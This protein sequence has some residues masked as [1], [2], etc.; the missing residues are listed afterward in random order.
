MPTNNAVTN[1]DIESNQAMSTKAPNSKHGMPIVG[2]HTDIESKQFMSPKVRHTKGEL[3]L[4]QLQVDV[5]GTI[6]VMIGRMWDISAVTNRYLSTD[7]VVSDAKSNM[8]HCTPRANVAHNFL[9]LKERAIYSIK[10][11]VVKPN[12]EEYHILKN[13]TFMLEFDG[14]TT[15]IKAFVKAEVFVRYPFQLADFD[16]IEPTN[17]KYL[18]GN[19]TVFI[20]SF[21]L[22]SSTFHCKVMIESMRTRKGWN[23]LSWGGGMLEGWCGACNTLVDYPVLRYRLELVVSDDT[24]YIVFVLFDEPATTLISN[25]DGSLLA[26]IANIVGTTHVLEIKSHTY[27]EYGTFE[28]F[29]C[30]KI[31]PT[32]GVEESIGL[33]TLDVVADTQTHKLKRLTHHLSIPTPLKLSEEGKK[34]RVD[35]KDYETEASDWRLRILTWE[36]SVVQ[37]R[38]LARTRAAAIMI[39]KNESN[40]Y[41]TAQTQSRHLQF[42]K[43][44][45]LAVAQ[46]MLCTEF[47]D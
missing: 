19:R 32:K 25:D 31:N 16:S 38:G 28:S 43:F 42:G 35:I 11:F 18:I 22:Q 9:K 10:N 15:I 44:G 17:N 20:N 21:S 2:T 36:I 24:A 5:T 1:A 37:L 6:V 29:M 26:A 7:F 40:M 39:R 8:V 14:S 45:A 3:F 4:D 30:W 13:D 33:S 41:M 47:E 46:H 27:Y 12:K 23:F 34:I